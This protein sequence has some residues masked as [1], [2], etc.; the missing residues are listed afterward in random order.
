MPNSPAGVPRLSW[1][2]ACAAR[3]D[4]HAL[5]APL[6]AGTSAEI[7]RRVCGAHAQVMSAAE[8]SIG[9][10]LAGS[11]RS[12]VQAAL[13]TD[14]SL[15][16]TFGPRGTVHLLP[17][18]DLAMWC[19]A[20]SAFP[21]PSASAASSFLTLDQTESVVSAIGA[22]L[23]SAEL[24]VDELTEAV[25]AACG[26]WAG[27]L[28][29]PAFNGVWPRWRQALSE[30][31]AR[32]AACFGPDRGR[33]VTYTSPRRWLPG[34][35]PAAA[36]GALSWLV[37]QYLTAYGPASP[38]QFAQ[39]LGAPRRWAA[40]LFSSLVPRLQRVE[41][42]E[43]EAWLPAGV[44]ARSGP[45]GAVRLLPYFDPYVVGCHPRQS[46]FPRQAAERG[47]NRTG[48]AGTKPVLLIE[49]TVA[50]LWHQRRSGGAITITVE[51]FAELTARQQRELADQ[52]QRLGQFFGCTSRL[53][54]GQVSARSHL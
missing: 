19:G 18:E 5:A 53:R 39:W 21:R 9:L 14:R 36:P 44:L 4:R 31:A 16:K 46:L 15:V 1:A 8:W 48:Q 28:V 51:P 41:L 45:P 27:D 37:T 54:L 7:V 34:F 13:W 11:S 24:T 50:G 32:G 20:L 29:I 22:A 10:R 6:T 42:D 35:E 26:A 43:S 52:A 38:A 3:L 2:Q 23:Q 40:E 47:L 25:V 33:N 17:A 49:G 30:A 12:D